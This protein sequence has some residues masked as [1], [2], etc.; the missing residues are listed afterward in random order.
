[1]PGL[2]V[3]AL[4]TVNDILR[5]Y[6]IRASKKLSQNFILD[7]RLLN[8]IARTCG[9]LEGK[10]VIEVGPGPG[11]ITRAV[12]SQGALTCTVIEKDKRFISILEH[13]NHNSG[14]RLNIHLGDVLHFNMENLFPQNFRK[15]W[16]GDEPDI[17]LVA[18]LPFNVS[19]P[20]IIK[21]MRAMSEQRNLFSYGRVPLLLTFQHEVAHR[22][23]APPWDTERSRLSVICQ[24][25]ARCEVEFTIPRG[26]FVPEP[27]VE[28]GLVSIKPL[29]KPYIDLPFP[30]VNKVVTQTFRGKQKYVSN[31]IKQLFPKRME[32]I[33]ADKLIDMAGIDPQSRAIELRM[34]DFNKLCHSYNHIIQKNPSL[35]GYVRDVTSD[36]NEDLVYAPPEPE[37]KMLE[38]GKL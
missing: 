12:L 24:N 17:R 18:N 2:R 38:G 1:M 13:L 6:N 29:V 35:A 37:E 32:G 36:P 33:L 22:M 15:P 31:S 23:I 4:P 9:P 28:V 25:Y 7:P 10:H 21:W 19:T 20:L 34:E 11:G 30:L 27:Q 16:E 3:P 5:M 26:A 14:H 8:R